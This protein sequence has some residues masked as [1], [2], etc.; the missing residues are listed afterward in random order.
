MYF[1]GKSMYLIIPASIQFA[2]TR[3]KYIVYIVNLILT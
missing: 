1:A 3:G 2:I